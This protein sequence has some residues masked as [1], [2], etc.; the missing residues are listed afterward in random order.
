M[1]RHELPTDDPEYE[2][3]RK[4]KE[5]EKLRQSTGAGAT[6]SSSSSTSQTETSV[7]MSPESSSSQTNAA[8][9]GL[10]PTQQALL[11]ELIDISSDDDDL[12]S[13]DSYHDSEESDDPENA[14]SAPTTNSDPNSKTNPSDYNFDVD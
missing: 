14:V 13:A 3:I 7:P 9:S 2:K 11:N 12:F 4:E 6:P 8:H 1:C 10:S 5:A